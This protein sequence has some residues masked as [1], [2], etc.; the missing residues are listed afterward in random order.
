MTPLDRRIHRFDHPEAHGMLTVGGDP[1]EVCQQ[2]LA[3]PLH[4]GQPLSPQ[5]FHPTEEEIEDARASPVGPEPIEL[6]AEHVG[7][8]G[9]KPNSQGIRI[10]GR[11]PVFIGDISVPGVGIEPAR[12]F[13]GPEC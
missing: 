12:P 13:R 11:A 3:E 2:E 4:L 7:F 10:R 1:V 8:E 5:G 6:L 9:T